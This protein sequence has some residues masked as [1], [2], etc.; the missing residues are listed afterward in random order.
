MPFLFTERRNNVAINNLTSNFRVRVVNS[1]FYFAYY[2]LIRLHVNIVVIIFFVPFI[3]LFR[4]VELPKS[5]AVSNSIA[6]LIL[7]SD[8]Q[9]YSGIVILIFFFF[10]LLSL[11]SWIQIN[12]CIH[13]FPR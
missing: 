5:K 12:L 1:T 7:D 2:D 11:F 8:K 10:L 4:L 13:A 3:W 9:L 6:L